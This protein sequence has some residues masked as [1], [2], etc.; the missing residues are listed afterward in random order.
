MKLKGI[1]AILLIVLSCERNNGREELPEGRINGNAQ[2]VMESEDF[3]PTHILL[4][5]HKKYNEPNIQSWQ[6]YDYFYSGTLFE[7]LQYGGYVSVDGEKTQWVKIKATNAWIGNYTG[8]MLAGDLQEFTGYSPMNEITVRYLILENTGEDNRFRIEGKEGYFSTEYGLNCI[9]IQFFSRDEQFDT[10]FQY[11]NSYVQDVYRAM[12]YFVNN[13]NIDA[14]PSLQDWS[15]GPVKRIENGI[16][17]VDSF[18]FAIADIQDVTI[19]RK[20]YFTTSNYDIKIN[21]EVPGYYFDSSLIRQIIMESPQYFVMTNGTSYNGEDPRDHP[22][23]WAYLN[24]RTIASKKFAEDLRSGI[25]PSKTLN[26]WYA[27]TTKILSGLK[28]E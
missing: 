19:S 15:E 11:N 4:A 27:E 25:H 21:M 3:N 10:D 22:I 23:Q 28:L 18:T 14:M 1:V 26:Q 8:W 13:N 7:I 6:P 9:M 20:I 16:K 5:T 12:E 17:I 24:D 2:N